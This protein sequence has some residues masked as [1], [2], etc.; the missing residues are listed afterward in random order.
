MDWEIIFINTFGECDERNLDALRFYG[1]IANKFLKKY[2]IDHALTGY[3]CVSIDD[4]PVAV[5]EAVNSSDLT[6]IIPDFW[7]SLI[8]RYRTSTA[9]HYE[10]V[11]NTKTILSQAL[12][13]KVEDKF[14][15]WVLSHEISHFALQWK[16][17]PDEVKGDLV[18]LLQAVYDKCKKADVSLALCT[19]IWTT[20]QSRSGNNLN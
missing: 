18:H 14:T 5:Q 3:A 9:G 19:E 13:L 6:I 8:Q 15:A 2:Q 20:V 16:G 10:W 4:A 12:T 11:G 7:Q 17:Y 1:D